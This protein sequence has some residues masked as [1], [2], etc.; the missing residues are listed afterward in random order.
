[1]YKVLWNLFVSLANRYSNMDCSSND[2]EKI[3]NESRGDE[4]GHNQN[5]V[6][7]ANPIIAQYYANLELPYAADIDQ[8]KVAW[9]KLMKLYHPDLYIN[10]TEK[11]SIASELTKSINNAYQELMKW[12][13][14]T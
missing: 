7:S 14:E 3:Y 10:N 13:L 5:K 4:T 12:M 8:I 11:Q 6:A 1:M 9:K 2:W